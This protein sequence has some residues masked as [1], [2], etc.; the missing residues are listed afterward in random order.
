MNSGRRAL[1]GATL[2]C[3]ASSLRTV[4]PAQTRIRRSPPSSASARLPWSTHF[5]DHLNHAEVLSDRPLQMHVVQLIDP[6]RL[7]RGHPLGVR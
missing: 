3:L 4:L 6:S 7:S 5:T 2:G 1:I